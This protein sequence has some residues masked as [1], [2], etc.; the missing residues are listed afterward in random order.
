VRNEGGDP[1]KSQ[2]MLF[3][4]H[5][6][7]LGPAH[8]TM[9]SF[10]QLSE[11]GVVPNVLPAARRVFGRMLDEAAQNPDP[12]AA[13]WVRRMHSPAHAEEAEAEAA[14]IAAVLARWQTNGFFFTPSGEPAAKSPAGWFDLNWEAHERRLATFRWAT[15]FQHS[16][17]ANCAWDMD[18]G[19]AWGGAADGRNGNGSSGGDGGGGD[20]GRGGEASGENG[21][22][23]ARRD[24]SCSVLRGCG[25]AG[26]GPQRAIAV[27]TLRPIDM[28]EE[29]TLDYFGGKLQGLPVAMRR[30]RLAVRGFV[31]GCSR[32]VREG[33]E[34]EAAAPL[35]S[36]DD[37]L[38]QPLSSEERD[39]LMRSL[40]IDT[41]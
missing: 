6:Q 41:T 29:L 9:Q 10:L 36:D 8:P 12:E 27:R 28:S 7:D 30:E 5:M 13:A 21:C 14:K 39:M 11:G 15:K 31:C 35:L 23:E 3:F 37:M 33:G 26:G 20:G 34:K 16:C 17:D 18:E 19:G 2:W 32:C 4:M 1:L 40:P 22:G 24:T 25:E 38:Q